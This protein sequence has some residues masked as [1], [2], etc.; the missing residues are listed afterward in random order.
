MV[1]LVTENALSHIAAKDHWMGVSG[2]KSAEKRFEE[3]DRHRGLNGILSEIAWEQSQ[4]FG[5]VQCGIWVDLL[6]TSLRRLGSHYG[7][8]GS[9]GR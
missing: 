4:Y 1:P 2:T 7:S 9:S 8:R 5:A 3:A 6:V